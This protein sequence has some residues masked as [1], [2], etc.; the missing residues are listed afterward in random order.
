MKAAELRKLIG[1]EIE[2]EESYCQWRGGI[3]RQ[4][5]VKEVT[6][7]NVL[8]DQFGTNNWEWLPDMK[9]IKERE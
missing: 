1:K 5:I 7:R 6:G 4:G 8:V 9:K 2:W 3:I